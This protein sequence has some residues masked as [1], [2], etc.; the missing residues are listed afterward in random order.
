MAYK[1]EET[2]KVQHKTLW[3][4][5]FWCVMVAAS[6]IAQ[7]IVPDKG[8]PIAQIVTI[9]GTLSTGYVLADKGVKIAS[10][11]KK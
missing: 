2:G 6:M 9:A 8:I 5:I 10:Q 1:N 7:I 4:V 11:V 3:V